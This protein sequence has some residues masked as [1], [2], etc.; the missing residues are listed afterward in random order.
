[1]LKVYAAYN[2]DEEIRRISSSGGVFY[3]I[4]MVT[5]NQGGIVWG[6]KY[7]KNWNV[8]H[9]HSDTLEGLKD[10]LGSKYAQSAIGDE[11]KKI[12]IELDNGRP[13]LF[14][15]TPC[16]IEGLKAYLGKV[17]SNLLTIDFICHGVPSRAIWREYVKMH[18]GENIAAITFR[19]K[20]EGW[21]RYSLKI[22]YKNGETYRKTA[23]EDLYFKGF[24]EDI[25]LRPSCY[26]CSFRRVNRV[27]D[28]TIADYWGIQNDAPE[29]FD[30]RG[31]SAVF[32]H[33]GQGTEIWH[34]ISGKFR[35]LEMDAERPIEHNSA[36]IRSPVRPAK[37]YLFFKRGANFEVLEMLLKETIFRRVLRKIKSYIKKM[38]KTVK[39]IG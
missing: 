32:V 19:D 27:S 34:Q 17:Y 36:M 14:S 10:F 15:G 21:L 3:E 13:C 20:T 39:G 9:D 8:I 5:I 37:R 31:T 22:D 38:I 12:K 7:D 26:E 1:M 4:A 6:A 35:M 33:S 18:D 29:M 25:Y 30:D 24:I 2:K 23:R 11:F 28:I 16:Q